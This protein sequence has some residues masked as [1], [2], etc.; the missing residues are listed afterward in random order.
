MKNIKSK[1]VIKLQLKHFWFNYSEFVHSNTTVKSTV[2][3][4]NS[5]K[6]DLRSLMI[7]LPFNFG[8][9]FALIM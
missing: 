9:G 1:T 2:N 5:I 6:S 3:E 8:Y 7:S 4:L